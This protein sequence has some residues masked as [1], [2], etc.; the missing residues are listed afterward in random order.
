LKKRAKKSKHAT[1]FKFLLTGLL[2]LL[3]LLVWVGSD[4]NAASSIITMIPKQASAEAQES[5]GQVISLL[6]DETFVLTF[7]DELPDPIF[8]PKKKKT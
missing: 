5:I 2:A 8:K 7:E 6:D 4:K 1:W 3:L